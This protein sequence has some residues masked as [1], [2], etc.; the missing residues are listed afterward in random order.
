MRVCVCKL[1]FYEFLL[2]ID[3]ISSPSTHS[4]SFLLRSFM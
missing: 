3:N 2:D 4:L 1:H